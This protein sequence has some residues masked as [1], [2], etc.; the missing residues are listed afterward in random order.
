MN[1]FLSEFQDADTLIGTFEEEVGLEFSNQFKG[2]LSFNKRDD[3]VQRGGQYIVPKA[4]VILSAMSRNSNLSMNGRIS[5]KEDQQYIYKRHQIN[6]DGPIIDRGVDDT[7][8][9]SVAMTGKIY[10]AQTGNNC[11]YNITANLLLLKDTIIDKDNSIRNKDNSIRT[12]YWFVGTIEYEVMSAVKQASLIS[13]KNPRLKCRSLTKNPRSAQKTFSAMATEPLIQMLLIFDSLQSAKKENSVVQAPVVQAPV[14]QEAR[15][16]LGKSATENSLQENNCL[17]KLNL[18]KRT[19]EPID[20]YGECTSSYQRHKRNLDSQSTTYAAEDLSAMEDYSREGLFGPVAGDIDP[21]RELLRPIAGESELEEDLFRFVVED[22][23]IGS[24]PLSWDNFIAHSS[25]T[26][27]M[28]DTSNQAALHKTM[29]MSIPELVEQ[30]AQAE[31]LRERKEN[32]FIMDDKPHNTMPVEK[33]HSGRTC[34]DHS[35][36]KEHDKYETTLYG[37]TQPDIQTSIRVDGCIDYKDYLAYEPQDDTDTKNTPLAQT[38]PVLCGHYTPCITI[39]SVRKVDFAFLLHSNQ[40]TTGFQALP[41]HDI[42]LTLY[43]FCGL[44]GFQSDQIVPMGDDI[45]HDAVRRLIIVQTLYLKK[46]KVMGLAVEIITSLWQGGRIEGQVNEES[47]ARITG[48]LTSLQVNIGRSI[49]NSRTSL[50]KIGTSLRGNL[51]GPTAKDSMSEKR[52]N[53]YYKARA[54]ITAVEEVAIPTIVGSALYL[55]GAAHG[56]DNKITEKQVGLFLDHRRLAS[57]IIAYYNIG[58]CAECHTCICLNA[59]N[60]QRSITVF[61]EDGMNRS[62]IQCVP[63]KPC[64]AI[65]SDLLSKFEIFYWALNTLHE[66]RKSICDEF[67]HGGTKVN[68]LP[69]TK[70]ADSGVKHGT[71]TPLDSMDRQAEYFTPDVTQEC[72][73][74]IQGFIL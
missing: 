14:V 33:L 47:Y 61:S 50:S 28:K 71:A 6:L 37:R 12:F 72:K 73:E 41:V 22:S 2:E 39:G 74:F 40:I 8:R 24:I 65:F 48:I 16:E 18:G 58:V 7:Y 49:K 69:Q 30:L 62:D 11:E 21:G 23:N 51:V 32:D 52:A 29:N 27:S 31:R 64:K 34:Y 53:S 43:K 4:S 1:T 44:T 66:R 13:C 46:L 55:I 9:Y 63:D 17:Y 57:L 54:Y 26:M 42:I 3:L 38:E 68:D 70:F 60:I 19:R 15:K 45:N 10:T 20:E 59:D 67:P 35:K 56:E 25:A 36:A 5:F